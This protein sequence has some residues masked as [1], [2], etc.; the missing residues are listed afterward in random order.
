MAPAREVDLPLR[1]IDPG[2]A[3]RDGKT[4][5]RVQQQIVI[6][7]VVHGAKVAVYIQTDL[8]HEG[9]RHSGFVVVAVRRLHGKVQHVGIQD[10]HAGRAGQQYIFKRRRL[11]NPVISGV[12]QQ[13]T[14]G[15]VA[16]N[17][18]ARADH[19]LIDD[20]LVVV[21][22]DACTDGPIAQTNQVLDER[23]LFE[24]RPIA[25]K[26]EGSWRAGIELRGIGDYVS[27]ALVQKDVV[28]F[29][30]GLPLLVAAM[31]GNRSLE[32]SLGKVV[33]LESND[34]SREQVR[35]QP[36]G[37]VA[38]HSP[39]IRNH[40]RGKDMLVGDYPHVFKVIATL[41][42]AGGLLH[43]LVGYVVSR[44]FMAEHQ[45]QAVAWGKVPLVAGGKISSGPVVG[46]V[47]RNGRAEI[48]T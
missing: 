10:H 47:L 18:Q 44:Q 7:K 34:G 38:N 17:S 15:E 1:S 24:V 6:G 48:A 2:F 29:H 43:L 20:E 23:R 46:V 8:A 21:P 35:R 28:R 33:A 32:V 27:E 45:A 31:N 11:E 26:A 4:D 5:R 37:V 25:N 22:A 3:E 19:V 16:R 14:A 42:L 9:L 36:I 13:L 40:V 12:D 30:T 41:L 39:K